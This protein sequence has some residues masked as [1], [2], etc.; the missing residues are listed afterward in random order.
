MGVTRITTHD[1]SFVFG[2]TTQPEYI[3]NYTHKNHLPGAT[4]A[5]I[6]RGTLTLVLLRNN[7]A[8]L[9][10]PNVTIV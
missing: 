8:G 7:C 2:E 1:P 3:H 6:L 9:I 10:R 4:S 5:V